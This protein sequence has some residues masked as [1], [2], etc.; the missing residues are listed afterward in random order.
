MTPEERFTIMQNLLQAMMEH[1]AKQQERIE[2]QSEQIDK[3]TEQIEKHAELIQKHSEQIEKQNAGIR[4]LIV[5]SRTVLNS[6][7]ELRDAQAATDGK[8]NILI[9]TVERVIRRREGRE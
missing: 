3:H 2:K 8:L 7:Q 9:D 6:V 1:D 5:V 4:D